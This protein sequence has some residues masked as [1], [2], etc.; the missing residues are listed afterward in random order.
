MVAS[1][2]STKSENNGVSSISALR[3]DNSKAKSTLPH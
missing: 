2:P 3:R 1:V